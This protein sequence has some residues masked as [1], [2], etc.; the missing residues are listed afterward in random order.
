M[1]SPG[2][3]LRRFLHYLVPSV[4]GMLV[5]S[6][7]VVVDGIFVGRGIGAYGIAAINLVWPFIAVFI[8][9]TLMAAIGGAALVSHALGAGQRDRA[10]QWFGQSL[11]LLLGLGAVFTLA[12]VVFPQPLC[13]L[14]GASQ[15]VL[16]SCVDYL[17]WYMAFAVPY[18]LS[19][20]LAA[21]VRNDHNPNLAF[22]AMVA[23][24]L[25][26]VSLD[27]LAIFVLHA[28]M[29]GAAV[30]SG[31]GQLFSAVLLSLH[32]FRGRGT[33]RL[34]LPRPVLAQ[35]REIIKTGTPELMVNLCCPVSMLAYNYALMSAIGADGVAAYGIIAYIVTILTSLFTGVS[36]GIQPVLGYSCGAGDQAG[37][38][39]FFR[40]GLVTNFS[41]ASLMF[42]ALRVWGDEIIGI[43]TTD[44]AIAS[45]TGAALGIYSLSF[46]FGSVNIVCITYFLS[47]RQLRLANL[48]SFARGVVLIL[49][50]I[51]VLP[52][53]FGEM[54][55]WAT[56]TAAEAVTFC[57]AA[58]SLWRM[59]R[60]GGR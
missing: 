24:A 59:K 9:V 33:L 50:F 21:F 4:T 3:T 45:M 56:I 2:S 35:L 53:L 6:L 25:V 47:V 16:P 44:P 52:L 11:W 1:S 27:Y 32:F 49:L 36:Q 58:V 5:S 55:I 48:L 31:V 46:L 34:A 60:A 20:G 22:V 42:V 26:N 37:L 14:M 8:A 41:L 29:A 17:R 28:G 7:Y 54:G 39:R 12:A 23:G 57:I 51:T 38:R 40:L 13:L 43:F 18:G 19:M 30:A 10:Q 15:E